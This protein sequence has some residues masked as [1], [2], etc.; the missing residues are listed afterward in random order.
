MTT[1]RT[2]FPMGESSYAV[3]IPQEFQQD[4]E[5]VEIQPRGNTRAFR[6][7]NLLDDAHG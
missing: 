6:P 5:K 1:R 4:G 2:R 7:P 3:R